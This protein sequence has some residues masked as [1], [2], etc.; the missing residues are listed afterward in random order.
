MTARNMEVWMPVS[1]QGDRY[2]TLSEVANTVGVTRQ[3]LWRWRREARVPQGSRFRDGKTLFS[4]QEVAVVRRFAEQ[5][6]PIEPSRVPTS[7]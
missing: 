7:E 5:L 1:I 6:D 2:L 4:E 3:T